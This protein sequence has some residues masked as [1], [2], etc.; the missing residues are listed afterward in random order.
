MPRL[1]VD[2]P[3]RAYPVLVGLGALQELPR[4]VKEMGAT[5]VA[6]VSDRLVAGHWAEP[7]VAGLTGLGLPAS[8]HVVETG[9]GAK[10]LGTYGRV[11]EFLEECR[12]DRAG[13]GGAVGGGRVGALAGFAAATWLRGV[14]HLQ[15]PT[16]LLAMV[17]SSI[18]GKTGINTARAKNSIGA[19][20]Q[21]AA[22]VA[23]L[24][25][26]STLPDDEYLAA[27]GEIVKYAVAMDGELARQLDAEHVALRARD[28]G[29]LEPVVSRCVDLKARVV[30]ADERESG[31]R[32]I[33]NYGH[34]VGHALEV[35]S[36]YAAAHG[37]AVSQGMRVAARVSERIGLCG[38]DVIEVQEGLLRAFD[39]PGPLP[40]VVV[41]DVLAA[42]QRDKKSRGGAVRWV[43]PRA[44][45]KAQVAVVAP[46]GV[47][48]DVVA[49]VLG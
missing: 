47:V 46:E 17:D 24:A 10:S 11:L 30:V 36:G 13:V 41:D 32:A 12:L 6:V 22:V 27:F 39:L 35:A 23:D 20:W 21:P 2:L 16:S 26:L 48:A 45:G 14:R 49:S 4:L 25:T 5:G 19:F 15:V 40:R 1:T 7:V 44:V 33:L 42:I 37:R 9:E 18:G 3:G 28:P 38:G 31:P 34:T 8:L 29:A 43:L